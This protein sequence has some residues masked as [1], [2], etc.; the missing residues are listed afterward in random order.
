MGIVDSATTSIAQG[1]TGIGDL[2]SNSFA[3]GM[4]QIYSPVLIR[5]GLPASAS[6]QICAFEPPQDNVFAHSYFG[7]DHIGPTRQELDPYFTTILDGDESTFLKN[8]DYSFANWFDNKQAPDGSQKD[9]NLRKTSRDLQ[10]VAVSHFRGPLILSGWGFCHADLPV[11]KEPQ[12]AEKG[13]TGGYEFDKDLVGNRAV[14]KSG[15]VDLKWDYQ[16]KVWGAGH[17]ILVGVADD[18]IEAPIN[19]CYPTCFRMKVLRRTLDPES[20]NEQDADNGMQVRISN[21]HLAEEITVLNR[22][23]SLEQVL[24]KNKVFVI[25]VRVNYEWLPLWVG[26]PTGEG[27]N[28]G[29]QLFQTKDG[30]VITGRPGQAAS[31]GTREPSADD[32]YCILSDDEEEILFSKSSKESCFDDDDDTNDNDDGEGGWPPKP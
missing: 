1:A 12:I 8:C 17:Q 21:W 30:S 11:P 14:W 20:D 32:C 6:D 28:G 2:T 19:P 15:P 3:S 18:D 23:P 16:R 7:G 26:C 27:C 9:I 4:E 5:K 31:D 10:A 24:I 13:E 22:D 29:T 25:A